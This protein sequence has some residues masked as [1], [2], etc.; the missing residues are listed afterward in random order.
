MGLRWRLKESRT[1]QKWPVHFVVLDLM[2]FFL[3]ALL[4]TATY[5]LLVTDLLG[6]RERSRRNVRTG[7]STTKSGGLNGRVGGRR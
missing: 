5:T 4:V 2:M 7:G 1:S 6:W 3:L